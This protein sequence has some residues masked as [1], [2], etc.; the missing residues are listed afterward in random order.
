MELV[1]NFKVE[2]ETKGTWRYVEVGDINNQI[3]GTLY[4]K[5]PAL[6]GKVPQTLVVTVKGE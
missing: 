1:V 4:I 2:K 3:I 6:N 5:K